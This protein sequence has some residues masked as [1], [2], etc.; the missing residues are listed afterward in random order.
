MKTATELRE[1]LE[2]LLAEG[3]EG[4]TERERTE[5]D[6]I[7]GPHSKSIV[8]FGARKLGRRTLGG[9]RA[10]GVE[11]LA[12]SDNNAETWGS[13]L[14]GLQVLSPADAVSRFGDSAVFVITIWGRGSS[15]KMTD[16]EKKL[17]AL[18]AQRVTSFVPLYW[19]YAEQLLPHN[20][21]DLPH[22]VQ[23][24]ADEVRRCFDIFAD[25]HS[26]DQFVRQMKW[27]ITGDFDALADPVPDE[28][29]F[30]A[31]IKLQN[32]GEAFVDCGAYDGDTIL[33]FL[34]HTG[35]SFR[36]VIAF[37]PDPQNLSA[38]Q[39][40][41]SSLPSEAQEKIG[42]FPYA[43][44]DT[45]CTVHFSATG[46]LGAA[47]GQ[48]SLEVRCVRLD[49]M[50][51]ADSPTFIKMDIEAAEPSA[52]RGAAEVI[53]RDQPVIAACSYHVQDH[54][55]KIPL[56]VHELN[57]AYAILLRQH[58]QLVEDLVCYAAPRERLQS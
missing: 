49:D 24:H 51:A 37:E 28:I 42:V 26:R 5:F 58:I 16:R 4:A 56:L 36:K 35:G 44:G 50:L 10:A 52:L 34:D 13:E 48:G 31:E 55:W 30:P 39:S 21:L 25:D 40:T 43:L 47:I 41:I 45:E 20:A 1:Q 54:A 38:L 27:R 14:D 29:Y 12:F 32:K 15:D 17:R 7:A 3:V 46:T 6:R 19:K 23:E 8:L 11:P 2:L 9:L 18:G 57:P 22:Y 53:R 33:R